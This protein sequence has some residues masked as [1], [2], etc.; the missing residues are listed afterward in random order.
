MKKIIFLFSAIIT[1]NLT[2][3]AQNN[4]G[5]G[6]NT[7]DASA[8][9][10]ITSTTKGLLIPRITGVQRTAIA[11][12]ATGLLVFDTDTK[13]IWTYDGTAWKNLYGNGGGGSLT[14]PYSQ[15]V[16]TSVS[17]LQ[18][19]NQGM[20]AALE[21]NS[22]NEFGM[23][24]NAKTTG[25]YGWG[26]NAFSNRPGANSIYAVAD[27]G[28]V[29][30]GENNYAGNTSTLMSLLNRGIGKTT[31]LQLA[32]TN[33]TA[34][35]MQIAGNNLAEQ[36]MIFQ[37]NISNTAPAVSINNSGTGAGVNSVAN[38]GTGIIGSSTNGIGISGISNSNYAVKGVTNSSTGFAGVYGQN[39]GTAGSGVVGVSNTVNTQGVY[40]TS[41]NGIGVR[42]NSNNY[43]AVDAAST[44]GTALYGSSASGLALETNGNIKIAGGNTNPANGAV[45]TSD[46]F[47]NAAWKNKPVGFKAVGIAPGYTNLAQDVITKVQF[48]TQQY[49]LGNNFISLNE[50][51]NTADASAFYAPVNG[52]YHFDI[53]IVALA[54]LNLLDPQYQITVYVNLRRNGGETTVMDYYD[55]DG[56]GRADVGGGLD[57]VLSSGDK[58]FVLV[59][60]HQ[61]NNFGAQNAQLPQGNTESIFSGHLVKEL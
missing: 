25:A 14:L 33:S 29:F 23:G 45:L 12:P 1:F 24:I 2:A 58:I 57:L 51:G 35:N 55:P 38:N 26:L 47:G 3:I 59:Q 60:Y 32:N 4:I 22:S 39:T 27:S 8:V 40:G 21:G 52:L 48:A 28:A 31:T 15:T 10:D 16:N 56:D 30:H 54:D 42:A 61:S 5:I 44:S 13:T 43:R 53:K 20:G 37:T 9:L 36:L 49:D 50:N 34:I 18:V 6:T 7:P 41:T 46:Q 11:S 19:S 17:A